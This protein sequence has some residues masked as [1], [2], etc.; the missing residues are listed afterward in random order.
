MFQDF[1]LGSIETG[2]KFIEHGLW[3]NFIEL[4][5]F[6]VDLRYIENYEFSIK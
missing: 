6:V 2:F 3:L 5:S 1:S 4:V